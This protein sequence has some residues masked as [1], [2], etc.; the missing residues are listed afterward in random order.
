MRDEPNESHGSELPRCATDFIDEVTKN[1]RY[2]RKIRE[3]VGAELTAHFEDHLRECKGPQEREQMCR[4]LMGE[5]G[6]PKLLAVLC[7]RAKKRCR[8]LWCKVLVRSA[9]SLSMLILYCVL[10]SLPLFVGKPTVRVDYAKWLSERWRPSQKGVENAKQ[11]YDQA[12]KLYIQ[13]PKAL[14]ARRTSPGWTIRDC[15]EADF[16]SLA[17]WLAQ[18]EPAFDLLRKGAATAYYWPV[19]DVA[20]WNRYDA[21][22]MWIEANVV[23][24]A[25]A[26][27]S[28]YKPM[29]KGLADRA[30]YRARRGAVGEALD[31]CLTIRRFGLHLEGKGLSVEQ[32]VGIAIEALGYGTLFE[33]LHGSQVPADVLT[34][35]QSEMAD[36]FDEDRRVFDVDGAKVFWYDNI[37]RTFTDDGQGDGR[38]LRRGLPFA[39][40]GLTD[41]LARTLV[42]DY[43]SRREAVVEVD[44]YFGQLQQLLCTW[45]GR[46]ELSLGGME[47]L[48]A[49]KMNWLLAASA[50]ADE[51]LVHLVW[52]TKTYEVGAVTTVAILRYKAEKGTYPDRLDD[53]VQAGFLVSV[54]D[55]PF[56]RGPLTYN[57]AATGFTLYSWGQNRVD[58]DGRQGLG[59]EGKRLIWADNGDA[60]F[61]PVSED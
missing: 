54:P 34:R 42:F 2:R 26:S 49:S 30:S 46:E 37:Q 16:Q 43:P 50:P 24:L 52:R 13:P 11:Y 57:K 8:P 22:F 21:P 19:Y 59:R 32:L 17:D 9:Q 44:A 40:G 53:L 15:N 3:D 58:D 38:A 12:A 29:A 18:N 33:V 25:L 5:F 20:E 35:V 39:A 1:I 45:P 7:R 60:V 56:G 27:V 4:Q 14:E 47:K 23:P 61:W 28:P 10:C 36:A 41:T 48:R 51:G 31:D 6:D 55:D